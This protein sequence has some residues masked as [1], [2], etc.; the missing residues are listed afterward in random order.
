MNVY[1]DIRKQKHDGAICG[2][3]AWK[4]LERKS[5]INNRKAAGI[6]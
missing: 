2:E 6:R 5:V 3:D 4:R 1:T